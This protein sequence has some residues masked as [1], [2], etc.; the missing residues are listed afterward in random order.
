MRLT[1]I[2]IAINTGFYMILAYLSH[3]L[4]RIN[5]YWMHIFGFSKNMFLNGSYWQ[6]LTSMFAHFH[7]SHLGFNMVF[8]AFFGVKGEKIYGKKCFLF[9]YFS[10]GLLSIFPAFL[11]SP[12]SVSAG[13]SGAIFGLT[14]ACLIALRNQYSGGVYTA[15]MFGFL[16]FILSSA[17]GFLSHLVGILTGFLIGGLITRDWYREEKINEEIS[18][19]K[20]SFI[21]DPKNFK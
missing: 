9:I 12:N 14:G 3:D 7:L 16:F 11:Y 6:V 5:D 15:L 20:I 18:G 1:A 4:L 21:E 10:C 13:A 19:D 8:L 17:T 2:L